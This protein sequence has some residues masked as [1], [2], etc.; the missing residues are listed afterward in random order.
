[1]IRTISR[2][3]IGGY[4]KL[5]RFPFDA[6]I[7]L[8]GNGHRASRAELALDRF[9]AVAHEVAGRALRD[10][11]LLED[12]ARLRAATSERERAQSLREE[13]ERRSEQAD[14]RVADHEKQAERQRREAVRRSEDRKKRA[15]RRRQTEG[16]RLTGVEARRKAAAKKAAAE[17]KATLNHRAKEGRLEQLDEE[18]SA[19]AKRERALVAKQEAKRLRRAASKTKAARKRG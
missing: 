10:E 1:M 14:G 8:L 13:A 7:R 17:T 2:S 6:G 11:E 18:A 12:G 19:L 16:R 4:L 5:L 9:D 15:D 3:A